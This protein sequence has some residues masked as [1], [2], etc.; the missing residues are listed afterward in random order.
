MRSPERTS[1]FMKHVKPSVLAISLLVVHSCSYALASGPADEAAIRN[2]YLLYTQNKFVPAADAFETLIRTSTPSSRLYYY[3]A[4]ANKAAGRIP[5][6][7]QLCQYITTNFSSSP[8]AVH[9]QQLFQSASATAAGTGPVP[10]KGLPEHLKGK[11]IDELMETEDG[12]MA[13]KTAMA[14]VPASGAR[15][16]GISKTPQ[17]ISKAPRPRD[18]AFTAEIIAAEG[19]DGIIPFIK[20]P[21]AG[22]ECSMAAMALLPRGREILADMIRCPSSQ[23]IYIVR[24]PNSATDYQITPEKIESYH[25]KD[26]ALWATLIHAAAREN[27]AYNLEQGLSMM[28]GHPAE[29]IF[30]SSTSEAVLA[31]FIG[32]AVR[33]QHPVVCLSTDKVPKPELV[34]EFAGYTI[35]GFDSASGMVTLRN[36]HAGNSRRFR[37]EEDPHRK[38]FEQMND[39]YFKMHVSLFPKYFKEVARSPL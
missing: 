22:L 28:T 13:L 10:V 29:K 25:M 32:D 15:S 19:A 24:F 33:N 31:L 11:S 14:S 38:K 1:D 39:G 12:R 36:P 8:E 9:A 27:P 35:T 4:A 26:K 5:R 2:A 18:A 34:E 21:D 37:L 16:T 20:K 3:A 6:A 7:Q 23:D 30:A 17:S